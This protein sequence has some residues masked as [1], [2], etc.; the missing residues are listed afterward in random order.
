MGKK[1]QTVPE[2]GERYSIQFKTVA[3]KTNSM[4]KIYEK[5]LKA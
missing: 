3:T 4:D 2:S 5:I 1:L